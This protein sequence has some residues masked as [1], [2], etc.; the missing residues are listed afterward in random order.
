MSFFFFLM[1]FLVI[2]F[3]ISWLAGIFFRGV[4]P[5]RWILESFS[6]FLVLIYIL[7]FLKGWDVLISGRVAWV[8]SSQT[9]T[10]RAHHFCFYFELVVRTTSLFWPTYSFVYYWFWFSHCIPRVVCR[11]SK[12]VRLPTP[13]KKEGDNNFYNSWVDTFLIGFYFNSPKSLFLFLP[14]TIYYINQ[15]RNFFFVCFCV[16]HGCGWP[17]SLL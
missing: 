11:I 9:L 14:L 13:K 8:K 17:M 5:S 15:I 7:F 2:H 16:R 6:Y 3:L 10:L 1:I 4:G 12:Q